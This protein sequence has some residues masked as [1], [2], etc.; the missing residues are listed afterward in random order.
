LE[1]KIAHAQ[2]QRIEHSVAGILAL[3]SLAGLGL[4]FVS[5]AAQKRKK[6]IIVK[7]FAQKAERFWQKFCRAITDGSGWMPPGHWE[8]QDAARCDPEGF[9]KSVVRDVHDSIRYVS[10]RTAWNA[11]DHWQ[12]P[13][14]TLSLGLGDCE[15]MALVT[16]DILWRAGFRKINLVVGAANG[17]GHA[18]VELP[19]ED[20]L[21]EPTNGRVYRGRPAEYA[22]AAWLR[23]QE[24]ATAV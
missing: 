7:R 10:D 19:D 5:I 3:S 15:D 11:P 9:V 18:W 1:A 2:D 20:L 23:P 4:L 12:S 14:Q 8:L 17:A 21:L 16:Y 13:N 24:Y 22:P 6:V